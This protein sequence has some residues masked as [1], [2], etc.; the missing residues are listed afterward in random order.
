MKKLLAAIILGS[1]F[2]AAHAQTTIVDSFHERNSFSLPAD[3]PFLANW[4]A[5]NGA[6]V[7]GY[8]GLSGSDYQPPYHPHGDVNFTEQSGH[9]ELKVEGHGHSAGQLDLTYSNFGTG[10]VSGYGSVI[11]DVL[12]VTKPVD[13]GW[14]FYSG[15]WNQSHGSTIIG[16]A[17]TYTLNFSS[18]VGPLDAT[19][20]QSLWFEIDVPCGGELKLGSVSLGQ[21]VATPE[22]APFVGMGL[23]VG[24][25]A[26][27]RRRRA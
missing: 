20:V 22:P 2:A 5:I 13:V 6:T 18:L 14:G 4:V 23:G 19:D 9:G 24:F 11:L 27:R 15:G 3:T 21:P 8:Q 12:K 16:S 25:L 1:G 17:G 26:L 10:D 7:F